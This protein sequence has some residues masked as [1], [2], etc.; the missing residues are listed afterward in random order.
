MAP[1]EL[2]GLLGAHPHVSECAVCAL[3]DEDH[4]TEVPIAYVTL[5]AEGKAANM[6]TG[7]VL[8]DIQKHVD[9]KVAPY[10]RLRGGVVALE[11]IPK[12]GTGKILR[13]LL[14]ARLAKERESKL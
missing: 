4:G 9:S 13:R 12:T 10:K 2:E 5:T 1:A 6:K 8:V 3:W 14:P 11:E 7:T